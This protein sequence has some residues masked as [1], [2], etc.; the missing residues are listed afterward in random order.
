MASPNTIPPA[1]PPG[2]N[3]GGGSSGGSQSGVALAAPVAR[4]NQL[5]EL[6]DSEEELEQELTTIKEQRSSPV[7]A[8]PAA[9][10]PRLAEC[11]TATRTI[12]TALVVSVRH[13]G[14]KVLLQAIARILRGS[15][16]MHSIVVFAATKRAVAVTANL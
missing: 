3:N 15:M 10:P 7:A 5:L 16:P 14:L 6:A 13:D 2:G 4:L 1:M 8:E 9:M 12:V 11:Y